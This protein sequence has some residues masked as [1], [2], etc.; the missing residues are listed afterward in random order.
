MT[1]HQQDRLVH[2]LAQ[3]TY[4][5]IQTTDAA[6]AIAQTLESLGSALGAVQVAIYRLGSDRDVAGE[7]RLYQCGQWLAPLA[8]AV[9][10][11]DPWPAILQLSP[12]WCDRLF[13]PVVSCY[14]VKDLPLSGLGFA[15]SHACW[16]VPIHLEDRGWGFLSLTF[17]QMPPES[18][19][20]N[21]SPVRAMLACI[22]SAIARRHTEEPL[23]E[24]EERYRGIIESQQ[25][26]I[27]RL[28]LL[29]HFTFVN[30]AYCRFFGKRRE[31][32]MGNTFLPLIH[33]E[34]LIK[35]L[36]T[37]EILQAPPY[38]LH[39]EQRVI[40]AQGDR[41]IGW[42]KYAIRNSLGRVVEIQA[43]GR[44]ITRA[45][46]AEMRLSRLN[47]EL[48]LKVLERTKELAETNIELRR[49]RGELRRT[50]TALRE[51]NH[52]LEVLIASSPAAIITLDCQGCVKTWNWAAQQI[53]GWKEADVLGKP[54]PITLNP[55]QEDTEDIFEK[56]LQGK[57]FTNL[58]LV[59]PCQD[60][61]VVDVSVS[62]AVVKNEQE[63]IVGV[64]GVFSDI[65][66]RKQ[67]EIALQQLLYRE[68][69][70]G[71]M[72]ERIRL[73]L[74]LNEILETT[75][76]EVRQYLRSDRVLIY[77]LS[78]GSTGKVVVESALPGFESHQADSGYEV[79]LARM[80]TWESEYH[81]AIWAINDIY[82]A[83]LTPAQIDLLER[84]Q[85]K[86]K[87]VVPLW[88]GDRI[89]GLLMA[90][91]CTSP[92]NWHMLEM[93]L[94]E[95]L[96]QRVAIAIQ[97][98]ELYQNTQTLNITLEQQVLERT[99]Q[100]QR[101]LGFDAMLKR[102][103]DKVRDSL[104]EKQIMESVVKELTLCLKVRGCNASLYD[105]KLGTSTVHYEYTETV[106]TYLGRVTQ[107]DKFP[108]LYNQLLQGRDFQFCSIEPNPV[109]GPVVMLA[110]PI[111]D[112][113]KVLGD[114]W[115]VHQMDYAFSDLELRL[116]QQVA[117]QCG[118]A[119]RQ[120]RLYQALQAQV[121]ELKTLDRLKDEFMSA[122][123][124]E[125]RTPITSIKLAI[126]MLNV[127]LTK[128]SRMSDRTPEHTKALATSSLNTVKTAHY[129]QILQEECDREANLINDL[130]DWQRLNQNTVSHTP[131]TIHLQTWLPH[132]VKPLIERA[133]SR[134][135]LIYLEINP[136][137]APLHTESDLLEGIIRELLTNACKYSPPGEKI[138][139]RVSQSLQTLELSITNE[140][141]EIPE[142]ER[143]LIFDRFYRIPRSDPWQQ[144]G[145]G[146]GLAL[147]QKRV[148]RLGGTIT[149]ESQNNQTCFKVNLPV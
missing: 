33:N 141:V 90:H 131:E 84:L 11:P 98:S 20:G 7:A 25:D 66:A 145:T 18:W 70:L 16:I 138:W 140:G 121:E 106:P 149:V 77:R 101:A 94:L 110:C 104:D 24:S 10:C 61:S 67:A 132:I 75:V 119:L 142:N 71:S 114:L 82:Q 29:G 136:Q 2:C 17:L 69:L 22:G 44:D 91:Q 93:D 95:Q 76:K 88:I 86:A 27:I 80:T 55:S 122:V 143:S 124:H 1:E 13:A 23:R 63:Q 38:H 21:N 40:T 100:L 30:D 65:T 144:G 51:T 105:L 112:D 35:T 9:A 41:W 102:I 73:S 5:L 125:L 50:E 115:L 135:Q 58:E 64:M 53:F 87:L 39:L 126:Q 129:L 130:L 68:R 32:L 137:L 118:I 103:A 48:E 111:L 116:V 146:L 59:Y 108:E 52:A 117:N 96:A 54:L 36:K 37:I 31:E 14:P 42:E 120:A 49:E 4:G 74:N 79:L 45:K 147:V 148:I 47:E 3:A 134:Q 123:Q 85:V 72:Q 57:V 81:S 56:A 8:Q 12:Q 109:R 107:L 62:T 6:N 113:Q 15:E 19:S 46:L 127:E 97:Q 128:A 139:V 43:V 99:A 133:E 60:G 26:L 92:R 89:W 28:N 78:G 34:D 83:R